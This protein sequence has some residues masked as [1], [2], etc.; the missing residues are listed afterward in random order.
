MLKSNK[1]R[2]RLTL[3]KRATDMLGGVAYLLAARNKRKVEIGEIILRL[4]MRTR[5]DGWAAIREDLR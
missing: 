5:P 1:K 4:V 2:V 3:D